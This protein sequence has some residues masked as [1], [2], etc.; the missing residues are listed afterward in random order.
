MPFLSPH[1]PYPEDHVPTCLLSWWVTA[2]PVILRVLE[3]KRYRRPAWNSHLSGNL[4][5]YPPEY[6]Y[7]EPILNGRKSK[8]RTIGNGVVPSQSTP[9][10]WVNAPLTSEDYLALEQSTYG[11]EYLAGCLVGLVSRGYGVSVKYDSQRKR[12]N[13]TIYR[14]PS[15][16]N[17]RHLGLSGFASDVRDAVLVTLYRFEHKCGGELSDGL[18]GDAHNQSQRRFG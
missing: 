13:C 2:R 8:G 14:P 16:T 5:I 1:F 15:D 10:E 3:S 18:V 4:L 17:R 11:L 6:L 12:C 9:L 7:K